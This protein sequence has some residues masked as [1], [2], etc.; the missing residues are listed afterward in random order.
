MFL[1]GCMSTVSV[2][3]RISCEF[4]SLQ[5]ILRQSFFPLV[6]SLYPQKTETENFCGARSSGILYQ[7]PLGHMLSARQRQA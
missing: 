7:G 1:R 6:A 5:G 2:I 4:E 3:M